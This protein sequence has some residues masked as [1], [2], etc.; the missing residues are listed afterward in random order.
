MVAYGPPYL[1]C[2]I[3]HL[4]YPDKIYCIRTLHNSENLQKKNEMMA[5][6]V[7]SGGRAGYYL[8]GQ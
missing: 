6:L 7:L 5:S 1:N 3:H 2:E 8:I 4:E